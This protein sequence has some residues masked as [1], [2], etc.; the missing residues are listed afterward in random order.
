MSSLRLVAVSA[1]VLF[2]TRPA[3]AF[4]RWPTVRTWGFLLDLLVAKMRLWYRF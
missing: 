1:N 2:G 3:T 4:R